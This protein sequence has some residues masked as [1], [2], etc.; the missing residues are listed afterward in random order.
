MA[1]DY[2][3]WQP[4][5]GD[6]R[7]DRGAAREPHRQGAEGTGGVQEHGPRRPARGHRVAR[8]RW[9]DSLLA[10]DAAQDQRAQEG[11]RPRSRRFGEPPHGGEGMTDEEFIA[12]LERCSLPETEF[13][14]AAHVR[15]AYLYICAGS[16][17]E[18]IDRMAA[19]IRGYAG[20]LGKPDRYHDTITIG[21]L[22]LIRERICERGDG[23]GWR[24]FAAANPDLLDR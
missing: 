19:A 11:L 12:A 7:S 8:L 15:A 2:E 20:S 17:G 5:R 18:A 6:A 9:Q 13:T 3:T 23:G 14:H 1:G 16:F 22:A 24:A 10:R 21:F 4:D